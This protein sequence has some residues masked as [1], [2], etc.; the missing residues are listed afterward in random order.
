MQ[1]ADNLPLFPLKAVLFPGMTIPLHIFEERYRLLVDHCL[2][3][4]TPFGIVL[5]TQGEEVDQTGTPPEICRVGCLARIVRSE[6]LDDGRFF[7]EVSGGKRILIE[8]TSTAL[9]YLTGKV[10]T[11]DDD[12]D[13]S[14][15]LDKLYDT[16]SAHFRAYVKK[17]MK[18]LNRSVSTIQLPGDPAAL[19]YAVAGALDIPLND[20]QALLEVPT[21]QGR[22]QMEEALLASGKALQSVGGGDA[23]SSPTS[24]GTA[25]ISQVSVASLRDKLSR[26]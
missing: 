7:V 12:V 10:S 4:S 17:L 24:S 22:L 23:D 20:K 19:S 11:L 15:T 2:S 21:T 6:Q 5:I 3:T 16:V 9:P 8:E 1:Y 14:A 18:R 25:T 26:N 13:N